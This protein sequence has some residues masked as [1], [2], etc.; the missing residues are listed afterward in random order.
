MLFFY[1]LL[2]Y[3]FNRLA[4]L[5][6]FFSAKGRSWVEGQRYISGLL[7]S[8]E[9]EY[10]S[11]KC[12]W[13]HCASLGEYEQGKPVLL[14]LKEKYPDYLIILTFF[15]PSGFKLPSSFFLADAVFPLPLDGEK[16]AK[17]WIK[18]I[19][20]EIAIFVKQE[21]WYHYL[22]ELNFQKIPV[23]LLSGT[24]SSSLL[25]KFPFYKNWYVNICQY[26]T[27][28]F[29]QSEKDV[30]IATNYQLANAL[31]SGNTRVDSVIKNK[32]L[33]WKNEVINSFA[34]QSDVIFFGS[35]WLADI[36]YLQ[37]FLANP[38]FKNWK[39]IWAPH[40]ISLKQKSV[41]MNALVDKKSVQFLSDGDKAL[42][43]NRI[44][45]LDTI[46]MLKYAYRYA[47]LVYVGGGFGKGIHNLLEPMVYHLPVVFGPNHLAFPEARY[48]VEN[49]GG[50]CINHLKDWDAVLEKLSIPT[51]REHC[52]IIASS[53]IAENMGTLDNILPFITIWL[54][55]NEQEY[56]A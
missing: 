19:H 25:L 22:K 3:F 21:F 9:L 17:K 38:L 56:L 27:K 2:L 41:L 40:D 8:M 49:G 47:K 32:E 35:S 7:T 43:N 14:A 24:M 4:P 23:F 45:V 42:R 46:G 16:V 13:M 54:D 18:A 48:L 10:S 6:L 37:H 36:P 1:N 20:P 11:S 5:C 31:L 50:F 12:I 28:L 15:S 39:I 30:A 53:Y 52:G 51:F 26:F 33:E 34:S 44:L 29:L 55:K